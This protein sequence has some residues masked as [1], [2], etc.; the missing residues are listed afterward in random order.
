MRDDQKRC[1]MTKKGFEGIKA[2][3]GSYLQ[4]LPTVSILSGHRTII[5][6][7]LWPATF[8]TT[9]VY[10]LKISDLVHTPE[11]WPPY[12]R[13]IC[14]FG[15]LVNTNYF[16]TQFQIIL[17]HHNMWPE[18]MDFDFMFIYFMIHILSLLS[19][20]FFVIQIALKMDFAV[21]WYSESAEW[22]LKSSP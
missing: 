15:I 21:N 2:V 10:H 3:A 17:V 5:R 14:I 12:Q 19:K 8:H 22:N 9:A 18:K 4:L 11:S 6:P 16:F 1:V 20:I 7:I 13:D